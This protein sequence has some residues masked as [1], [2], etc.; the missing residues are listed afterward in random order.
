MK[1][2]FGNVREYAKVFEH[3]KVNDL[4]VFNVASCDHGVL[5]MS[6]F[7][8]VRKVTC[9]WCYKGF[10][11]V[12]WKLI[13]E[14][15][16]SRREYRFT[17]LHETVNKTVETKP[18]APFKIASTTGYMSI[19]QKTWQNNTNVW[20][21]PKLTTNNNARLRKTKRHQH[22]NKNIKNKYVSY[23]QHEFDLQ[24]KTSNPTCRVKSRH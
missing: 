16:D 19:C 12:L 2:W 10:I 18:C 22:Q 7:W 14:L 20:R 5:I 3:I 15:S 24:T 21:I 17:M 13:C 6:V 11:H 4:H 9:C 23:N 1:T 8:R